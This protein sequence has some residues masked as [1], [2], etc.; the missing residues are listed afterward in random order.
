MAPETLAEKAR[1]KLQAVLDNPNRNDAT[2]MFA[3]PTSFADVVL[4]CMV[5]SL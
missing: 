4:T 1:A 2:C 5:D 3:M